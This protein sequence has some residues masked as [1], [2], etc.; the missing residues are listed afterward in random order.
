MSSAWEFILTAVAVWLLGSGWP[1]VAIA[2]LLLAL[3]LRSAIR[4]LG[5]AHRALYNKTQ[6]AAGPQR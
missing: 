1:D 6:V 4:V 2:M 5:T 3:F